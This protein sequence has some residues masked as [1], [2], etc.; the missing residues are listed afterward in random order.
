MKKLIGGFAFAS[1]VAA[2]CGSYWFATHDSS[3]FAFAESEES[4]GRT[5]S[6]GDS[7][8]IRLGY[9]GSATDFTVKPVWYVEAAKQDERIASAVPA[10]AKTY[11][12]SASS[13]LALDPNAF[14]LLGPQPLTGEGFGANR[15]AGRVNAVV[16]DPDNPAVAWLGADGGGVWKTTNCCTTDTTWTVK[17]DFPQIA[18][19]AIDD[20]TMDPSNHNVLYA[21][22][23]DL[24]YGSF[25]FGS[26]GVL[27]SSDKGET[28]SLLGTDVFNMMYAPSANGFPQYQSISK[29]VVDP[30]NS[31]NVIAGTKTGLYFSY[32]A[33]VNWAGP[34]YTNNFAA[35][36]SAQRQDMTGLLAVKI[37][38][39]TQLYAAVGTRGKATP[40]QPDLGKNGANGVY[41]A[42][43]PTSGCPAVGTWTLLNS[44][45]PAGLGNGS[46]N[47]NLGR[48]EIAAAPSNNQVLYAMISDIS[49]SGI[50]GI[51]K[52]SNGGTSW[53]ASSLPSSGDVGTQ[54]WYDAGLTV[55]P[56]DPTVFFIST[57]DL[58]VSKDS[59]GT[60]TNL[61]HAYSG[62]PVH[63]DNHARA[64]VGGN[65][66]HVINGNDGGVYY[67]SNAVSGSASPTWT[68]MNN[69]LPTIEVYG[70]NT[71]ANFATAANPGVAAG[72]QDNGSATAAFSGTPTGPVA[73]QSNN[74]GDGF[75]SA[76]EPVLGNHWFS[77]VY[78]G[79]LYM[80]TSRTG[81]QSSIG[82]GWS[83]QSASGERKSFLTQFDLYRYGSTSVANSGCTTAS[84]CT[85]LI[86]GTYRLW[87]STA[88]TPS[89][90]TWTAKTGDLSKN[91]LIIGTDNR[92]YVTQLHYSFTDPTI[93][94]AGTTDGNVQYVFGLG[95]VGAAT[96]VNVTG[97]NAVLPN[98]TIQD[99][100]TDPVNPLI[101]YAA[102]AGFAANTPATPGHV[103]R[104]TCTANCA[105]FTWVD[106]SGNL[107]D[108]P[109]DTVIANPLNTKQVFVGMDWGL[110]YT[111]DITVPTPVW[112]RFEGLP[113]VMVWS[114]SIDRGFT[115]LSA[116]TRGRGVWAWPLPTG[117]VGGPF[118][119][120]ATPPSVSVCAGTPASYT[121]NL[122][123]NNYNGTVSL[124]AS[125]NPAPSTVAFSP[126]SISTFPGSSAMSVITTGVATGS[127]P[128]TITG[129]GTGV[130]DPE[131]ATV[132][133]D[134]SVG[135]PA[136]ASLTA[137]ANAATGV[138]TSPTFSWAA[139]AGASSYTL[140][141]ASDAAFNTIVQ[142]LPN[143]TST[144]A[145]VSGLA[146]TTTYY[147]RVKA[148]NSC[149]N[150]TSTAFN[151]T[152][153]NVL[154]PICHTSGGAIPD[155][156]ATGVSDSQTLATA[157]T[158]TGLRISTDISHTYIGDLKVTVSNGSTT[159]TLLSNPVTG[160]NCIGNDAKITFDDSA[161][162]SAQTSCASGTGQ[163]YTTGN[164]YSPFSPLAPFAGQSLAGT[165][166]LKIVDNAAND[167]GTLNSWCLVPTVAAA[168]TTYTVGG[169]VSGL[170]GSGLVLSLN[171]GA[172]TLPV[173]ANGT[174]TFPTGLADTT[175]YAVTVGTQ[176][177]NPSETCTVTNGSG[178]VAS[179]NVT[180]VTVTCSDVIF[181]DGFEGP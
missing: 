86:Y 96:A 6:D 91:N 135:N 79:D 13:P 8:A 158:L 52:T 7:A 97:S 72:F 88:A 179:A 113:H 38:P 80:S 95:G 1:A 114:L 165:W 54:M 159:V 78:Y 61:T 101:G 125:G 141:V 117:S 39:A 140:E 143:L 93:A 108:I 65:Q 139:S 12:R 68:D 90:G 60:Y 51:Y 149:G 48:I 44:G 73:W 10:G 22:T 104:V 162:T 32:D 131:T 87:E 118:S 176:P 116:Y 81:G 177:S 46:P 67:A 89:S 137:P 170:S 150:T 175:A 99:V 138:S 111:N 69:Q 11:V 18:S 23:G 59:G 120:S 36:P 49:S 103:F 71:T 156:N 74:G 16:S 127:Y 123:A 145:S 126:T 115:T 134:V 136:G 24:N 94:M 142:S 121:V 132:S 26:A 151:F 181:K 84:G 42:A 178:T 56:T 47:A 153:A 146:P 28:W 50:S 66:D 148:F 14:T 112:Q 168:P 9:H 43:M 57:V 37:G 29:V 144:T 172:Q 129:T 62:G 119:I 160:G 154:A 180:N 2:S 122:S 35:G 3:N 34:C 4:E 102:V 45:M 105:S 19:M 20:I 33:G 53:T 92:S 133:L 110:Y 167:T 128:I 40:V 107:P 161:A 130:P 41:G 106:K 157:G 164:S 15:A 124:G 173:A 25:S 30:N 21:G 17:T 31:S 147:W 152:T 77:S 98:R 76:I 171:G 82:G 27:K 75:Y 85:H 169:N 63:P 163:A 109:A 166:T 5:P 58:L 155:N 174:F 83:P 64:F 100:N 70:G 55:S